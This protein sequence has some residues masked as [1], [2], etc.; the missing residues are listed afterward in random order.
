M[1]D[2]SKIEEYARHGGAY[3]RGA[4]DSWYRRPRR[5]HYFV[6]GSYTSEEVTDLT[7]DEVAAYH[8]GFEDNEASG[9]HKEWD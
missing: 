9:G 2:Y 3:D 6:G 1:T 5:P 7:P 4:A 8:Q